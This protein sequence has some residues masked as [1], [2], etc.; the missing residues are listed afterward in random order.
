MEKLLHNSQIYSYYDYGSE[1]EFEA[2]IVQQSAQ[3]FGDKTI[4]IDIK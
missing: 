4:Y 2:E 1:A 3:I